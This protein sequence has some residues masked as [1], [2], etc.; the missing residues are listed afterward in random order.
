[1]IM[2]QALRH[3][4]H[5]Y[6]YLESKVY[7]IS[8]SVFA[9]KEG[10]W[11]SIPEFFEKNA[12]AESKR[13]LRS[14]AQKRTYLEKKGFKLQKDT[15]IGTCYVSMFLRSQTE[16]FRACSIHVNKI[17]ELLG[18]VQHQEIFVALQ[19]LFTTLL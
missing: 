1:M 18:Q 14:L 7:H 9:W 16:Y 5:Q 19:H 2:A 17:L 11:F 13:K 8:I 10:E 4:W 15:C 12:D 3:Q 6:Q